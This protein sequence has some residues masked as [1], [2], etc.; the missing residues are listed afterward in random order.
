MVPAAGGL[1]VGTELVDPKIQFP[2]ALSIFAPIPGTGIGCESITAIDGQ[3]IVSYC[4]YP[5]SMN[6]YQQYYCSM[7][8]PTFFNNVPV[9]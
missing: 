7:K 8:V 9:N 1:D 4:T 6:Y 2:T 5:K 3:A